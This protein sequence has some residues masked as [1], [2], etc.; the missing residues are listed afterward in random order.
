MILFLVCRVPS[1]SLVGRAD[2]RARIFYDSFVYDR[3]IHL[4]TSFRWQP[5]QQRARNDGC[6]TELY[7]SS[8]LSLMALI[9]FPSCLVVALAMNQMDVE[10]RIVA[11]DAENSREKNELVDRGEW[12]AC[13]SISSHEIFALC[14]CVVRV[15][16]NR[17]RIY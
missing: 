6:N 11:K 7:C 16:G 1:N 3:N 15:R 2:A 12:N 10:R 8:P 5:L 17:I 13:R 14:A 9:S 4:T